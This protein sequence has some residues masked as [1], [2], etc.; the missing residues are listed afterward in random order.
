MNILTS[1]IGDVHGQLY[2]VVTNPKPTKLQEYRRQKRPIIDTDESYVH[3]N[4]AKPV[5]CADSSTAGL[6]KP[7]SKGQ[8]VAITAC[9]KKYAIDKILME[10]GHDVLR[11][12]PYHP[13]LN[14]L[15]HFIDKR[16]CKKQIRKVEYWLCYGEK[17]KTMGAEE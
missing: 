16:L 12:P 7:I 5:F 8:L 9:F 11:L 14:G 17:V 1:G 4:H 15:G 13:Y 3:T 2:S 10:H 6:K